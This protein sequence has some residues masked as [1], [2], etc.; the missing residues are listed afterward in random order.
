MSA[1]F[2]NSRKS[3]IFLVTIKFL[4]FLEPGKNLGVHLVAVGVV[5]AVLAALA[6]QIHKEC[7]YNSYV[8]YEICI[9]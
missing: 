4:D 2:L 6:S 1:I 7:L 9:L 8:Y 3:R 5:A